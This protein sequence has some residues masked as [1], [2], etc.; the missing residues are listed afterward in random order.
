MV[1][2]SP[3]PCQ[4]FM[5]QSCHNQAVAAV[6]YRWSCHLLW[7]VHGIV[8][9]TPVSSPPQGPPLWREPPSDQGMVSLCMCWLQEP[10]D[11]PWMEICTGLSPP[12]WVEVRES[13]G[14][15]HIV[16]CWD[17]LASSTDPSC[18]VADFRFHLQKHPSKGTRC[19]IF[20]MK[21]KCTMICLLHV[22]NIWTLGLY[23]SIESLGKATYLAICLALHCPP[24]GRKYTSL[25]YL[26]SVHL[27][28]G[29][30]PALE[31]EL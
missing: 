16:L 25:T 18:M 4:H 7:S 8:G 5:S 12:S 30:T 27:G 21:T 6:T 19:R 24:S 9:L 26:L 11:P 29:A 23:I 22:L 1:T 10:P 14:N 28:Q 20:F 2:H 17:M 3:C 31:A 15:P 13:R